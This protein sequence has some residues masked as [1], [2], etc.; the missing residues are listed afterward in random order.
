VAATGHALL[1]V[2]LTTTW[3]SAA[4]DEIK[5]VTW[6]GE[7]GITETVDQIMERE[8]RAPRPLLDLSGVRETHRERELRKLLPP[9]QPM[10]APAMSQWPPLERP[11]PMRPY[12]PQTVG[13]SF[14]GVQLSETGF[15]IPPDSMGDVGPTQLLVA[16]NGRIKVFDKTGALGGLDT[17]TDSF[18]ASVGGLDFGT[19]DPHV[20][21]DRLSGRWFVTMIDLGVFGSLGFPL[22]PNGIMIAVSSGSTITGGTSFTFYRFVQDLVGPTPNPDTDGFADYDT[23]GVDKSALYIGVN[24]FTQDTT[25]FLGTTGFVVKKADLLTGILTVTAFRQMA[26]NSCPAGAGPYTPQGV[27]N[28]DPSATEGYFI[29]VDLCLSNTLTI[30]RVG[31]PGGTPTLSG[32]LTVGVPTSAPPIPQVQPSPS[33][34]LDALDERLLGAMIHPDKITGSKRLWTAHTMQVD[35]SGVA[36]ACGT[37]GVPPYPLCTNGR[38]GSRWYEIGSLT[39][40]PALVQAGTVFDSA[41]TNPF[42][43]W[44]P[45]V[46]VSG[47]GHMALGSS[48]AGLDAVNG[49]AGVAAA[50]RLRSDALG[51]TQSPTLAQSSSTFYNVESTGPQRWG[52]FSQV[53]VDPTDDMTMWT[54]QEYCNATNSWGVRAIQLKAPPPAAPNCALP[55]QVTTATQDVTIVGASVMG[56]EFF[57]PGPDTGGPGYPKHLQVSVSG[58]VTVNG[59]TFNGPTSV[60]LNVTAT[61]NGLKNVTITNPDGQSVVGNNCINVSL[62]ASLSADLSITKTDGQATEVPGTSVTYTIVAS[63]AGPDTATGA[64][65]ADTVPAAI[66][67][68]SWTCV[69]AGGGTCAANGSGNINDTVNLPVGGSVTYTLTGTIGA[70]ATGSLSNTATVAAPGGVTDPNPANNSATDTDTLTPQASLSITKTD[71]QASAAPGSPIS[72]T[73]VASNAGPSTA[74]GATVADTVPAAITGVTWTC[75]GAGGGTCGPGASG[76]VN[77]T[78]NLPVGGTATYTLTGTIDPSATG[79]LSNTATVAAPGGVTDPNPANNSATDTDTLT[80]QANLSITKTD[81]QAN[82][83]PGSPITYTILASNAGPSTA[84]GATVSDTVPAAITGVNWTCAGAGGGT[85]GPGGP[86][87][88]NDT[89][90]LP[91]GG[92]ST[93]TLTGTISPSAAGSLSNTAT[94]AA[95]GGVTDPNPANNSATDTDT[96]NPQADLSITKTDGLAT[97]VPGT[98][99]TYTIVASNAGPTAVTGATVADMVPAAITGATWTCL[100]AGGGTC[101][102]SGPGNINDTVNLPVGGTVTYTLT[103]TTSPSATGSLTNTA[104][105]TAPGGVTDPTPGNNSAADTDTLTPQADLSITKTDGQATASSGSPITYTIVASNAGPSTATGA[106]VADTVPAAITGATW[107]CL[108]AGGGTCTASGSGN[109]NDTVNLP[110]GG[111]VTYTL[112]GTVS[113]SAIGSLSNTATVTAPGGVSDPNPAN[114]SATDTDTLVALDYF[115]LTPCR[116]VDT[117]GGAPVGGPVLQG[118]ETRTLPVAGHCGIPLTAKALSIN[119]TVTQSSSAGN[120][121][122]FPAGQTVPLVSTI[123]YV[124]GLT[125]ANNAVVP[126]NASGAM[127]AYVEQA[128]GT[129]VHLIIDVNGY[130]E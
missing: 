123:N 50:G 106:T 109:I 125:R 127:A 61:T 122:L 102:A 65:V 112:T 32:N 82:A 15:L 74:N 6:R 103:G 101:A 96:L 98:A 11:V 129:T 78:A 49:F 23:L 113:P 63:N 99:I 13:T 18:F 88:I 111:S 7:P 60:T 72:Y 76:N 66:T 25:A 70:S 118:Q 116:V 75:A 2:L 97:E 94:I 84:N 20:R 14:L 90:N 27:N 31:S 29:G 54:F 59:V 17:S 39:T 119:V 126:L 79:S 41:T 28:D 38:N 86:G 108:G 46:A 12:N 100:G 48:R 67:G 110:V 4:D 130:F 114:N 120:V 64:T 5:G 95:P 115:T 53:G 3:T 107:T 34:T 89:V 35:S 121:R 55:A 69:G 80:P 105:V 10:P 124:V 51:T 91:V 56:A 47:Q 104:T 83:T 8:R 1:V 9:R 58:G 52:D 71:G 24:M 68:V 36:I 62:G 40:T 26:G 21:Y 37:P 43:Y 87:N 128:L 19:S 93:Y 92:T 85:C 33:R 45:S 16:V 117:R 22:G 44:I 81:G 57:D 77:D 42:G 73:I 30:R